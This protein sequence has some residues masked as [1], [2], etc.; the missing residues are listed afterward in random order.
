MIYEP[1][2]WGIEFM[3]L[4]DFLGYYS[5]ESRTRRHEIWA[6]DP[7]SGVETPRQT[8]YLEPDSLHRLDFVQGTVGVEEGLSAT[9]AGRALLANHPNPFNPRTSIR[10]RLPQGLTARA[11]LRVFN[12]LGE[13]VRTF[14]IPAGRG[15]G[16]LRWDGR[17]VLGR[18]APGGIYLV[19]LEC[20]GQRLAS[21]RMLLLR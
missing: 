15:D 18:E 20:D 7:Q 1:A 11:V 21:G 3:V 9:P 16:E 8:L 13:E 2:G 14:A 17:D 12:L 5:F 6:E 4:T 19:L 10:W